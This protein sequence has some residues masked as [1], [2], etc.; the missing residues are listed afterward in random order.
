MRLRPR[1]AFWLFSGSF[2]KSG[3]LICFSSRES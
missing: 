3:S 1:M 2:Q